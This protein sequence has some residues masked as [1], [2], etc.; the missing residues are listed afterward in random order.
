MHA[1]NTSGYGNINFA[2]MAKTTQPQTTAS[3]VR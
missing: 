1:C 3:L 2:A